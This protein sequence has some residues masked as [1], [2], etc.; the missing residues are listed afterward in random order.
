MEHLARNSVGSTFGRDKVIYKV[1]SGDVLGLIA[2]RY[3][4][5]ISDIKKWNKL[6]SNVIRVG[7]RLDIW[8]Y[9]GTKSVAVVSKKTVNPVTIDYSGKKVYTVQPG[10]TLWD[11]AKKYEGLDIW[12]REPGKMDTSTI[13]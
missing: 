11:I 10:D 9:P 8:V 7:Q 5:R 12:F 6:R 3:R 1:R 2:Q 13:R 4:V